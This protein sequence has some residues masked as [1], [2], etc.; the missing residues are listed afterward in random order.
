[1]G[2]TVSVSTVNT[3]TAL[4]T[5]VQAQNM[6]VID[7]LNILVNVAQYQSYLIQKKKVSRT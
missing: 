6:T 2:T 3:S 1:M 4:D 7:F 5:E